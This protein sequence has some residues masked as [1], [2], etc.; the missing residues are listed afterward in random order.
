MYCKYCGTENTTN[1]KFCVNCGASVVEETTQKVVEETVYAEPEHSQP[2]N[3]QPVYQQPTY[4]QPAYTP[5]TIEPQKEEGKG[6]AIAGMVCGI[7]SLFCFAF[8]LGTLGIVFGCVAK[9]KGYKGG[10]ATAGIVCGAIGIVAW[11]L[12]LIL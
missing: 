6:L 9:S 11:L 7:I 3:E 8:I 4:E 5:P 12:M 2:V 10:M 1:T